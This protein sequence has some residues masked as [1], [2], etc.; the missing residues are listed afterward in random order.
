MNVRLRRRL[1]DVRKVGERKVNQM[2]RKCVVVIST[3]LLSAAAVRADTN[4]VISGFDNSGTLTW[5]NVDSNL[6]YNVEWASSLTNASPWHPDYR[7]LGGVRSTDTVISVKVPMFYRISG[8]TNAETIGFGQWEQKSTG[9]VYLAETDGFVKV[10]NQGQYVAPWGGYGYDIMC[11]ADVTNPPSTLRASAYD[12]V[13]GSSFAPATT[14]TLPVS[15][16]TYWTVTAHGQ[17]TRI[18]WMNNITAK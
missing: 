10:F 8:S 16:G 4:I 17:N 1:A 7:S 2:K 14:I 9:V 18:E 12:L 6:S 5:T 15:K 13:S 11:Y 3:F